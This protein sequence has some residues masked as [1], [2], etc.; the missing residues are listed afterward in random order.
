MTNEDSPEL[1]STWDKARLSIEQ[2]DYDTTTEACFY[3]NR[4]F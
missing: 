3:D 2:C 1:H 4:L